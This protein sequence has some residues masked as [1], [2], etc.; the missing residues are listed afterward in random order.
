MLVGLA[1]VALL[2]LPGSSGH[3]D[4]P[5]AV[6]VL[7]AALCWAAGSL[8]VT[9][10]AV[11]AEPAVMSFIEMIAGGAAL[12]VVAAG[13]GEFAR[14]HLADISTKSWLSLGYL[15]IFGSMIAFSAYVSP[16]RTPRPRWSPPTPTSTRWW[17]WCSAC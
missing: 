5:Y 4:L 2:L 1:G 9:R 12:V 7:V 13:R 11:P 6:L 16:W 15:V 17:Q 8:L 14:L 3:V 10:T